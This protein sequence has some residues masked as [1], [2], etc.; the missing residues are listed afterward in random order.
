M[1]TL[2]FTKGDGGLG[3]LEL[4]VSSLHVIGSINSEVGR[5]G[6]CET[7]WRDEF[8]WITRSREAGVTYEAPQP[9]RG[10]SHLP[11]PCKVSQSRTQVWLLAFADCMVVG[12]GR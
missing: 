12:D 1:L 7:S 2:L 3:R 8:A 10:F 11:A 9:M 6:K 5:M 4:D